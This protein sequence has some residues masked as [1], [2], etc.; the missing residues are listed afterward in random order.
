MIKVNGLTRH[1]VSYENV[2]YNK[3]QIFC[4][5]VGHVHFFF[6]LYSFGFVS[7]AY[8]VFVVTIFVCKKPPNR[9]HDVGENGRCRIV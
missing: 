9:V 1:C 7:I 3:K 2:E 8:T 5:H 6:F 4:L